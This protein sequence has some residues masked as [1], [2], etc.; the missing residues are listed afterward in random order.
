MPKK[1]GKYELGR[2]LGEGTFAKV[3]LAVNKETGEEVAIK[4]LDK[5]KIYQ[6]N[7]NDQI[8]K[9]IAIMKLIKHPNVVQMYETVASKSKIF[10]VLE[11]VRGGEL[12]DQIVN[13]GTFEEKKANLYFRQLL[14]GM[15]Y[16]HE[17]GVCHRD[18]KPE[19]VLYD[20]RDGS[21]KITDFGLSV[22]YFPD[23][24]ADMLHTTC[25][26]PNY[27]APEVL[28]DGGYDGKSADCWSMGVMLFVMLAGYLPFDE[29]TPNALFRKVAVADFSFPKR[30]PFSPEAV[31]LI[32]KILVPNP[33]DR[34]TLPEIRQH[35]WYKK[36]N[37]E[38]KTVA[39][40]PID[41]DFSTLGSDL[42]QDVDGAEDEEEENDGPVSLNAFELISLCGGMDLNLMFEADSQVHKTTRFTTSTDPKVMVEQIS[43]ALRSLR[44]D[45]KIFEKSYKLKARTAPMPNQ[46]RGLSFYVQVVSLVPG[47]YIVEMRRGKGDSNEFYNIYQKLFKILAPHVSKDYTFE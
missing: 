36:F 10:I 17:Q 35:P 13:E 18:L 12:F 19:N 28:A 41:F 1:V 27:V 34:I 11:L 31:D 46:P 21:I 24:S 9:E 47:L 14:E 37:N 42:A 33:A 15:Q 30:R 25:G 43:D 23:Q 45:H 7:M 5:E 29:A 2:T 8:K 4:I 39:T 20:E 3:K 22:L 44:I 26:T 6:Q 40:A 16:C 38:L 32:S